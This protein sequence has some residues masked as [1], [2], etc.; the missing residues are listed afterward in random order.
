MT[1]S[2][3]TD[4]M[5]CYCY[6]D[7]RAPDDP[8]ALAGLA[9]VPPCAPDAN[10]PSLTPPR[11]PIGNE[12]SGPATPGIPCAA[13][14]VDPTLTPPTTPVGQEGSEN[15]GDEAPAVPKCP[16]GDAS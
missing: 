13:Y 11:V 14:A 5:L 15:P 1:I 12:A 9:P 4:G 16:K 7:P 10:I 6:A 2:L 3:V 8:E